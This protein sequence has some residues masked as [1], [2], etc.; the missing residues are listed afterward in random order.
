MITS[1]HGPRHEACGFKDSDMS[2]DP[3]EGHRQRSGKVGDAGLA[4]AKCNEQGPSRGISQSRIGAIERLLFKHVVERTWRCVILNGTIERFLR[5]DRRAMPIYQTAHYQVRPEA[6]DRVKAAIVEF[7]GYVKGNEPGSRLYSA[8]Q[9]VDDPTKFVHLFIFEDET[10]HET[11]GLSAAVR[12]FEA[13]YQPELTAGPV[14]FTDYELVATNTPGG[15][16]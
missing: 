16:A 6:V 5:E 13:V 3:G 9:E 4:G 10:A 11:H 1:P 12:A 14:V 8:W 7:V 15:A 2:G